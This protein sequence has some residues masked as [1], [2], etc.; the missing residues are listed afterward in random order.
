MDF[1]LN[2]NGPDDQKL[3]VT[4]ADMDQSSYSVKA[5]Y[6]IGADGGCSSVCRLAGIPFEGSN[7]INNRIRI[8][9]VIGTNIPEL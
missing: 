6:I 3:D 8:D 7:T 5:K 9:S 2:G 1:T 4:I